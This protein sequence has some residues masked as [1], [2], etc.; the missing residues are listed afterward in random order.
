MDQDPL[1]IFISGKGGLI[2]RGSSHHAPHFT[3]PTTTVYVHTQTWRPIALIQE[4]EIN[5][6]SESGKEDKV[7]EKEK[8]MK[9]KEVLSL[10]GNFTPPMARL[11]SSQ[12]AAPVCPG[13]LRS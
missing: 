2:K 1:F 5:D 10:I 6:P 12:E 11:A 3:L 4:E 7:K 9:K 13:A 8:K